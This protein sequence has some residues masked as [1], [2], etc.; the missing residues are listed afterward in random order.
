MFG[1]SND[2][3]SNTS[4]HHYKTG[5]RLRNDFQKKSWA[6]ALLIF[7][8]GCSEG[9]NF[10]GDKKSGGDENG[11]ELVDEPVMVG[12]AY[13]TCNH[14]DFTEKKYDDGLY[15][16]GCRIGSKIN[17]KS[18]NLARYDTVWVLT[19][20]NNNEVYPNV[21]DDR[22]EAT[23]G[24]NPSGD[25]WHLVYGFPDQSYKEMNLDV[26]VQTG[27]RAVSFNKQM[28][29]FNEEADFGMEQLRLTQITS[30]TGLYYVPT[31]KDPVLLDFPG[32]LDLDPTYAAIKSF[33]DSLAKIDWTAQQ[34]SNQSN[35]VGYSSGSRDRYR[36]HTHTNYK[37]NNSTVPKTQTT[38][39]PSPE[40]TT[41]PTSGN[42]NEGS[43]G[44]TGLA[45]APDWRILGLDQKAKGFV[46]TA[47]QNI[48]PD[49]CEP[50]D[51]HRYSAAGGNGTQEVEFIEE[52]ESVNFASSESCIIDYAIASNQ[53]AG[54]F[55]VTKDS[56]S[57]YGIVVNLKMINLNAAPGMSEAK[58]TT[59]QIM[60]TI[61][62]HKCVY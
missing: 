34:N 32:K 4:F 60:N 47:K 28:N 18:I 23:V 5:T 17:R 49:N 24:G 15:H 46:E 50:I 1:I 39:A 41:Q 25:N 16:V 27:E 45:L 51:V 31:K 37:P 42:G 56:S 12:G 61:K 57:P 10:T 22:I 53:C 35:R 33:S 13:L 38:P 29:Q 9:Q 55:V 58:Y 3:T 43:T 8:M 26:S 7:Y 14:K 36:S 11:T 48:R 19:D 54:L 59:Q 52:D 2:D 6:L 62:H 40:S 20:K 21:I 44:G 30:Q